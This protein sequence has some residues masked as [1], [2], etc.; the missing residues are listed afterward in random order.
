MV[1]HVQ[2]HFTLCFGSDKIHLNLTLHV[3]DQLEH[4]LGLFKDLIGHD[5]VH[6][7]VSE[8]GQDVLAF[9]VVRAFFV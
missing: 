2:Q 1:P 6:V 8:L 4:P 7:V 5:L 9:L 3:L